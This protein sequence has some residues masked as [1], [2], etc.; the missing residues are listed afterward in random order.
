MLK[1]CHPRLTIG[2]NRSERTARWPRW[3]EQHAH[4]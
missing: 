1:T 4:V 3:S 2:C